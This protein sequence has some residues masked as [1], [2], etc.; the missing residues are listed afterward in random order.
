MAVKP[1]YDNLDAYNLSIMVNETDCCAVSSVEG[2]SAVKTVKDAINL[3]RKIFQS[4]NSGY[5]IA[6]CVLPGHKKQVTL[7]KR[8]GWKQLAQIKNPNTQRTIIMMGAHTFTAKFDEYKDI[9]H[10]DE[11][12]ADRDGWW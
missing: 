11:E 3:R 12:A 1:T 6:T 7:L 10:N 5:G 2:I 8:G 4:Q 9:Y